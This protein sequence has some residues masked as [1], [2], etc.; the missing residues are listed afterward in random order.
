MSTTHA[1]R[2]R[3]WLR[4]SDDPHAQRIVAEFPEGLSQSAVAACL[5]VTQQVVS[6]IERRALKKLQQPGRRAA[7]R[8]LLIGAA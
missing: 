6:A 5:G 1:S 7:L 3:R 4:W 2:S 8:R